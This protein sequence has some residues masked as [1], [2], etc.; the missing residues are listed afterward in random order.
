MNRTHQL[1]SVQEAADK[2]RISVFTLRTWVSQ[3]RVQVVRIGRRVFL[4]E[5][6]VCRLMEEGTQEPTYRR[7]AP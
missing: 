3:R 5:D 6:Y 4:T 2:L 7:G 1:L